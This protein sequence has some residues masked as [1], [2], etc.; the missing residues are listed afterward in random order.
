MRQVWREEGEGVTVHSWALHGARSSSP[1]FFT[2]KQL[3]SFHIC[4]S[5]PSHGCGDFGPH[6]AAPAAAAP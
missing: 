3:S 4:S 1:C 2:P 6:K 5:S